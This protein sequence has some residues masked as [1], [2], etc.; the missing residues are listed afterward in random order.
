MTACKRSRSP[1][2]AAHHSP[3]GSPADQQQHIQRAVSPEEPDRVQQQLDALGSCHVGYAHLQ[4]PVKNISLVGARPFSKGGKSLR[5]IRDFL[6]RLYHIG[7]LKESADKIL[8]V[9]D[10][11]VPADNTLILMGHNGPAGL[12]SERYN[13]CGVDWVKEAGDHGDPDLEIVLQQ[14]QQAGRHVAL[15]VFGHMH[16]TLKGSGLRQMVHVDGITGTV[17]LNAATVP[18]VV[19][20]PRKGEL[21]RLRGSDSHVTCSMSLGHLWRHC[22]GVIVSLEMSYRQNHSLG[23]IANV[24]C[25]LGACLRSHCFLHKG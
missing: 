4:L 23:W 5:T 6:L 19:K 25:S 15:V 16:H 12:G 22:T 7:E 17:Y 20:W 3:H 9:I 14:L 24:N 11:Q 10:T 8:D 21:T 13:I 2:A 1:P 18:R